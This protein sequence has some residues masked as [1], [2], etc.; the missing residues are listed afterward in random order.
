MS[1]P[2]RNRSSMMVAVL[3]VLG[4]LA[5]LGLGLL[6]GWVLVPVKYVDTSLA[7]LQTDH[8]EEY[9]L[10]VAS[11]YARDRN[12]DK[13]QGRLEELEVP[14]LQAWVSPLIDKA[15]D[16]GRDETEIQ[17]L[18]A[19]AEGLGVNNPRMA[20]YLPSPTP[21][22]TSTPRPTPTPMPT[23]TPL[24]PTDTPTPEPPT[25]TPVP[26]PTDTPVPP[27]DT[28]VPQPTDTLVPQPTDTPVLPTDTPKPKPTKTPKPQPTATNTP[29]PA[30][31]WT[32][33]A[34]LVGPGE[35]GQEC[36]GGG[37]LSLRVTVV[38]A[39]GNQIGGV[40][41]RNPYTG[42][43]Q[44]TGHKAGDP[45]WGIGEAEFVGAGGGKLC[46]IPGPGGDCESAY[47]RDMPCRD[48]P[49]FEDMWAAGYCNCC[50]PNITKERCQQLVNEGKCLGTGHYSWRIIF[51]RGW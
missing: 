23:D 1:D 47:T 30:A 5:G 27:T 10:L 19:L 51:K 49:P 11:A 8:K 31:K 40:W 46:I 38:D 21:L 37:N 4:L 17:A 9:T 25:D 7:D 45:G 3:V 15:I 29:K 13:A 43:E 41:V 24:P 28:P 32:W 16:Q 34:R 50:E 39:Q 18:V 33:S 20:A 48:M 35:D 44:V 42:V 6:I 26:Q 2:G 12:L 22:P 14:N 36:G